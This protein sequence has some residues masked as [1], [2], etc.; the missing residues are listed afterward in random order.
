MKN[1]I[2]L[3]VVLFMICTSLHAQWTYK[4]FEF[5]GITR[6]YK[7]YL[8]PNYD[9]SVPASL[10]LTLHGVVNDMDYFGSRFS[11]IADTANI[12][13]IS[14][15]GISDLIVGTAWNSGAGTLGYYPNASIDD[16][17][18]MNALVDTAEAN[19]SI[20]P[21]RIY[22]CGFSM[23][24]FMTERMALQS[25][26]KFAAFA[27]MSGTIGSAITELN[28]GCTLP[29]AHFHGTLDNT[30]FYILNPYGIDADSLVH[31]W[32]LNNGC[33]PTPE[34]TALPDIAA[35]NITIDRFDY[36]NG[37]PESEVL[38][39]R[40]N[41]AGHGLLDLPENDI[42]EAM[43]VWMFFRRHQK[44]TEQ[45]QKYDLL[46]NIFIYPNPAKDF[47]DVSMPQLKEQVKLDIYTVQ[48]SHVYSAVTT[49]SF[50]YINLHDANIPSGLLL[51]RVSC[52]SFNFTKK[53]VVQK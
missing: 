10:L 3:P 15:Q 1:R 41:G 11:N 28:P 53:I 5:G 26:Q 32:V 49:G 39:Y 17:G 38:F 18:F 8:S 9:P 23:G 44:S 31:F 14:P 30:V 33:N 36:T 13:V 7:V 2:L 37:S 42:S 29:I 40:M 35:D 48:G 51:L 46:N 47:I 19:Y 16:V 22:I 12:I 4:S 43:E 6:E 25:N 34:Y 52:G 45:I 24:G 50:H 21:T 20:D 27:S